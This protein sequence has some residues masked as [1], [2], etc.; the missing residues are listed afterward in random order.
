MINEIDIAIEIEDTTL[1]ESLLAENT[2]LADSNA[3]LRKQLKEKEKE[4]V[5]LKKQYQE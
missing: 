3:A 1:I 2:I 4:I 5:E